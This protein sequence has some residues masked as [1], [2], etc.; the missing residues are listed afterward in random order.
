MPYVQSAILVLEQRD[1]SRAVG[2]KGWSSL[3]GPLYLLQTFDNLQALHVEL[4]FGSWRIS[5]PSLKLLTGIKSAFEN[6][7][8]AIGGVS[9]SLNVDP[10]GHHLDFSFKL[11]QV[12]MDVLRPMCLT[13]LSLGT[14]E[15]YRKRAEVTLQLHSTCWSHTM[16]ASALSLRRFSA[17]SLY[18]LRWISNPSDLPA[19]QELRVK[20]NDEHISP[21]TLEK[22]LHYLVALMTRREQPL[23][24]VYVDLNPRQ[25]E[26]PIPNRL[27]APP[28]GQYMQ[29]LRLQRSAFWILGRVIEGISCAHLQVD[30]Y[31]RDWP[32]LAHLLRSPHLIPSLRSLQVTIRR[33]KLDETVLA[34]ASQYH[35]IRELAAARHIQL[36]VVVEAR[37]GATTLAILLAVARAMAPDLTALRCEVDLPP[38]DPSAPTMISDRIYLPRCTSLCLEVHGRCTCLVEASET[39]AVVPVWEMD[40]EEKRRKSWSVEYHNSLGPLLDHLECPALLHLKL[41]LAMSDSADILPLRAELE[42]G[43]WPALQSITGMIRQ[44]PPFRDWKEPGDAQRRST[45]IDLC[46]AKGISL[47]RLAWCFDDDDYARYDEDEIWAEY[48]RVD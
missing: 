48:N 45:I 39:D 40:E 11:L 25:I 31:P 6:L 14:P 5:K 30:V 22:L 37:E 15:A 47:D 41:S 4:D 8:A 46:A 18:W 43:A 9:L 32:H 28:L 36:S 34:E 10:D 7:Q 24:Y 26:F 1:K 16:S 19:L 23:R 27:S 42:R 33:D 3:A 13:D 35:C 17:D 44:W 20:S 29:T 21:E 12:L 38:S 2:W